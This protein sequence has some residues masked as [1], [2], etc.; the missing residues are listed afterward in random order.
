MENTIDLL[1][2]FASNGPDRSLAQHLHVSPTTISMARRNGRVSPE[3]AAKLASEISMN[4]PESERIQ[5]IQ[6]W[7]CI[8]VAEQ[9]PRSKK[10]WLLDI[11][12]CYNGNSIPSKLKKLTSV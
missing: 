3:L 10:E 9:M 4:K 5:E 6:K 8:A 12:G 1:N 11:I 2:H 7:I